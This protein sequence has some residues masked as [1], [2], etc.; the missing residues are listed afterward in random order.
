VGEG[1]DV[2]AGVPAEAACASL[3]CCRYCDFD[4]IGNIMIRV[5]LDT[6]VLVAGLVSA[7]GASHAVLRAVAASELEIAASTAVW[8]EYESVLK[9]D[10]IRAMHGLGAEEIDA[11]LS[12][13]AVWVRPVMLH[14]VWRPQ[15]RDPGDEMVLEAAVNG[16]VDAIVTH[17]TKD[18]A[19]ISLEFGVRVL[20]PQ[21]LLLMMEK[22]R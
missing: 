19:R 20:T 17:N 10:E 22:P 8:L 13:L 11:V 12:A 1:G 5:L 21:A 9:R 2:A 18:F 6:N 3:E 14:Y 16:R 7:R 4:I 15:L